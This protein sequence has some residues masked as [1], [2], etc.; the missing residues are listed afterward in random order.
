MRRS[1]SC[2][3]HSGCAP[4]LAQRQSP[5]PCQ[6]KQS[7]KHSPSTGAPTRSCP[8]HCTRSRR[9]APSLHHTTPPPAPPPHPIL[10]V[11]LYSLSPWRVSQILRLWPAVMPALQIWGAGVQGVDRA[12]LALASHKQQASNLISADEKKAPPKAC[13][14]EEED[15]LAGDVA[16]DA[17]HVHVAAPRDPGGWG[18]VQDTCTTH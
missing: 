9:G 2:E 16:A 6:A 7:T 10:P 5:S 13:L 18:G 11:T 8:S 1:S 14:H 3:L 17:V 15:Y 12:R 4:H